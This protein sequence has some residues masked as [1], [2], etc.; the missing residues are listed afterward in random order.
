[1]FQIPT[2]GRHVETFTKI[3]I[4]ELLCACMNGE[5]EM[6]WNLTTNVEGFRAPTEKELQ[7]A[8]TSLNTVKQG[9]CRI[10]SDGK[11]DVFRAA[12]EWVNPYEKLVHHA[13]M[14]LH[15]RA[16]FKLWGILRRFPPQVTDRMHSLH[17]CEAPGA[18]VQAIQH[19]WTHALKLPLSHWK[20]HGVTLPNALKWKGSDDNV[21]YADVIKDELPP[22]CY[23]A[24][25]VTGD[26]GFDIKDDQVNEQERLNHPLFAAQINKA[27][28]CCVPGGMIVIKLFDMF[29]PET[30]ACIHDDAMPWFTESFICKPYG[31]RICNSERFFVGV[32][33]RA[34]RVQMQY[35]SRL[36][37]VAM[38]LVKVQTHAL[39][40]AIH[41][42]RTFDA[43]TLWDSLNKS[44]KHKTNAQTVAK[45][46]RLND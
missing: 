10:K 46:L 36:R 16:F 22:S 29:L 31:S 32:G 11:I 27:V 9:I 28:E 24:N 43:S 44:Y 2:E 12:A 42:T 38:G 41:M 19:Y 20:W 23:H 35:T 17:L 15:S 26:G 6:Q 21:I 1:M 13:P 39:V 30:R 33:K 14:R 37:E 45:W 5:D 8:R 40:Q 7:T 4:D 3:L 34:Q 18:F 25:I